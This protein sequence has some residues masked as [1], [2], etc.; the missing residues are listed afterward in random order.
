MDWV[1]GQAASNWPEGCAVLKRVKWPGRDRAVYELDN[2]HRPDW[3]V[4]EV[5]R[6]KHHGATIE[7]AKIADAE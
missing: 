7:W 2:H 4:D 3:V 1:G 5:R 6:Y